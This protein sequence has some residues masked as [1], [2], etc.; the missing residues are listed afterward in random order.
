MLVDEVIERIAANVPALAGARTQGAMEF[1]SLVAQGT[2][3]AFSPAAFV[4][5]LGRNGGARTAI[6][7][8]FTQVLDTTF[9]VVLVLRSAGDASGQRSSGAL[10]ELIEALL[11][12]LPGWKPTESIGVV[13][14]LRDRLIDVAAGAVFYQLDFTTQ[15]QLRNLG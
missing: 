4:L 1:A 14:F 15:R 5:P 3:P 11:A 13:A 6:A 2:L 10:N 8:A 9:A 7:N 12:C